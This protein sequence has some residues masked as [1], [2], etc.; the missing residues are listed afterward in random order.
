M[1]RSLDPTQKHPMIMPDGT[2]I[3][4]VVH[5][6]Q[7]IDHP[8]MEVGDFSYYSDFD[9]V[10]DYAARIAP[11][12]FPPSPEKLIIGKFCQFAHGTRF[13]TS[14][15]NHDMSGFSTYPFDNFRMSADMTPEEIQALFQI[16]GRK[17]D[18]VIGNDVWT[19]MDVI[20]MP[21]VTIGDGVIAAAGSVVVSDIPAYHIIGGNPAKPLRP[22]FDTETIAA[23]ERIR[24]WDWPVEKIEAKLPALRAGNL[25]ALEG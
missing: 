20:V 23:L 18:T 9:T 1:P 3:E 17:G 8:R 25:A 15:A 16:P 12:L 21:G 10:E 5:L 22:R 24:W 2:V 7:V 14:S 4:T 19:G 13:V 11:Y 6:N